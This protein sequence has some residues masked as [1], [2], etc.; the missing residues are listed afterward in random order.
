[1]FN[2]GFSVIKNIFSNDE[3][4]KTIDDGFVD[5]M[6]L[7]S[8]APNCGD[9]KIFPYLFERRFSSYKI[10]MKSRIASYFQEAI[11]NNKVKA[12]DYMFKIGYSRDKEHLRENLK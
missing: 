1:M 5:Q 12:L 10:H 4:I 7:L 2:N 8:L 3:I 11:T 9:D 6:L